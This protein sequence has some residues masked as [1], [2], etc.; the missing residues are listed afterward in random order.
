MQ[1]KQKYNFDKG[2]FIHMKGKS[3]FEE[4]EIIQKLGEGSYGCVYKVQHKQTK[5]IRAVKAIKKKN[6]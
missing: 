2:D 1:K 4:Y 3:L 5:F 6:S